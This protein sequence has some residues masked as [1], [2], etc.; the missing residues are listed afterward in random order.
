MSDRPT[1]RREDFSSLDAPLRVTLRDGVVPLTV[2]STHALPA[3]ALREAPFS[4]V[5][6]GPLQS[7][8]PQGTF[9]VEH[10]V[11]G[12]FDLFL[13]PIARSATAIDYEAVFN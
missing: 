10:P 12:R 6:Q 8:L 7:P 13:V 1:L 9:A 4:V 2:K 3:H 5:L 11:R